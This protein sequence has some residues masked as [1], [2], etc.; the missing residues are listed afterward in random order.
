MNKKKL[1]G[2]VASYRR[3][4]NTEIVVKATAEK[5]AGWELSLIRLPS[6]RILPCKGCYACLMPGVQCN[7]DDDMQWLIERMIEAD[8]CIVA[9]PN[10]VLGPVG[11]MKMMAD[12]ALQT[13]PHHERLGSIKTAVAL[14]LGREDY[15]GYSDTALVSQVTALGLKV[16]SVELFHGT[17][18]GEAVLE[19]GFSDRIERLASSL[20]SDGA[21]S[22]HS[23]E[24]C[25]RCLSDLFRF[26]DGE[27]ECAVCKSRARRES[28]GL[29]FYYFHPEFGEEGQRLH[30]EWLVG[31]KEAYASMKSRLSEVQKRYRGGEWLTPQREGPA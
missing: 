16:A 19:E 12:R 31:K 2:L 25:P 1:L 13:S 4:G 14:T 10:Y 29:S 28:D 11:I 7:L 5:M 22:V 24:R 30:L 8:A 6:L 21:V 3:T 27:I 9:A 17:F 26:R 15:R 20:I 23:P 18:P